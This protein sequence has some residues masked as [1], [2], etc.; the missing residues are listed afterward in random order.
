MNFASIV[1]GGM[2]VFVPSYSFLN[3]VVSTWEG[4]GLMDKFR[5][6]KKVGVFTAFNVDRLNGTEPFPIVI[7]FSW[8]PKSL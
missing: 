6:K 2:V 3:L 8:S 4:N 5:V 7:R 1:P